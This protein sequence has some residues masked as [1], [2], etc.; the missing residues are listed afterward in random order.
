MNNIIKSIVKTSGRLEWN[1]YFMSTALLISSRSPCDRLHVGC[2]LVK[3]NR[4]ISAGYNGFLA[5]AQH[6]SIVENNHEQ[7][8]IHAE[9]NALSDCACRGVSTNGAIAYITHYPCIN[10]FKLLVAGGINKIMYLDDYK[11]DPNIQKI[12][13]S[14]ENKIEIKKLD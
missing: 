5:G 2:V 1:D 4:I 14:M 3:N 12:I 13:D 8:T 6:V 11:N 10:C 9:Q 7:A